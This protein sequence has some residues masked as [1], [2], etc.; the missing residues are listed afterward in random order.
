[1]PC[2]GRPIRWCTGLRA[3]NFWSDFVPRAASSVWLRQ[4]NSDLECAGRIY[5]E[6]DSASYCHTIAKCQ[7]VVEKSVK[8]AVAALHDIGFLRRGP[9]RRH[10]LEPVA[11]FGRLVNEQVHDDDC[12][13]AR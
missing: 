5:Q 3:S 13:S 12:S 4:T 2:I 6:K 1:M 10:G 7:Q 9:S 11:R 8:A